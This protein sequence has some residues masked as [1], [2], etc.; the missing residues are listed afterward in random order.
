MVVGVLFFLVLIGAVFAVERK[1]VFINATDINAI[2]DVNLGGGLVASWVDANAVFANFFVARNYIDANFLM[3]ANVN[4][5]LN[6]SGHFNSPDLNANFVPYIGAT[7][8]VNL[9]NHDLNIGRDFRID[10]NFVS[11]NSIRGYFG[12]GT[13]MPLYRLQQTGDSSGYST[14]DVS[15]ALYDTNPAASTRNW[16]FVTAATGAGIFEL[17]R[18]AVAGGAPTTTSW[19]T[20]S[21]G[22]FAV[23]G[24]MPYFGMLDVYGTGANGQMSLHYTRGSVYSQFKTDSGGKLNIATTG[25]TIAFGDNNV[26]TNKTVFA[27]DLNVTNDANIGRDMNVARD[28]NAARQITGQNIVV[29][30]DLNVIRDCNISGIGRVSGLNVGTATEAAA[31][32]LAVAGSTYPVASIYRTTT[33][34][35]NDVLNVILYG[36]KTSLDMTDGYGPAQTYQIQD[37]DGAWNVIGQLA[38]V[39]DSGVDNRGTFKVRLG[40]SGGYNDVI[41]ADSIG[42]TNFRRDLNLGRNLIV[43]NNVKIKKDLNVVRNLG[44]DGNIMITANYTPAASTGSCAKGTIAY[45]TTYIYICVATNTW[46]RGSI[47][48]W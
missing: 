26:S 14:A 42:D 35:S 43:E 8:D 18:S 31:N 48:T 16:R 33:T 22:N 44:V 3:N 13:V 28:I 29:K 24:G 11:T 17:Q 40:R 7:K 23:G 39:R 21:S 19:A 6:V 41:T 46:Y 15:W 34:V 1:Y 27:R 4:G 5:D 2:G 32:Q 9:G 37:S 30:Q 12:I 38:I 36:A 45:D 25:G 47:G 20:D 10:N